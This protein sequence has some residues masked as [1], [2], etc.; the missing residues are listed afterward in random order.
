M[1]IRHPVLLI[2]LVIIGLGM[3]NSMFNEPTKID[4]AEQAKMADEKTKSKM[5]HCESKG[6]IYTERAGA[7]DGECVT[8]AEL[9][10]VGLESQRK[11]EE[12]QKAA[13]SRGLK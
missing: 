2:V 9:M 12:A 13:A 8:A 11:L 4:P 1:Q 5:E 3:V 6:L 10:K 7:S